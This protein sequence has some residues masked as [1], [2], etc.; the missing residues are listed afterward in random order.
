MTDREILE[1]ILSKIVAMEIDIAELK[2]DVAILKDD[3]KIIKLV[4]ENELRINIQRVAEGHLDL[5]RNL[6]ESQ[7]SNNEFEMLSIRVG[8]L[9]SQVKEINRKIS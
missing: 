5:S 6:K 7:K 1:L 4:V 2:Q 8:T 9:E 3:V